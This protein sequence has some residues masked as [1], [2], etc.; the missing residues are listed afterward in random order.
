MPW[1]GTE[2]AMTALDGAGRPADRSLVAGGPTESVLHP[3]FSPAGVLW[4]VSD[5]SGWW[6]LYRMRDGAVEPLAPL[7]ADFGAAPWVFGLSTFGFVGDETVVCAFQRDGSWGLGLLQAGAPLEVIPSDLTEIA[8]VQGSPGRAVFAGGS[9]SSPMAI[10]ALEPTSRAVTILHRPSKA[11]MDEAL[12]SRPRPVRWPTGTATLAHGLH[13][14]PQN[15]D[16]SSPEGALPPLVVVSHGGPTA[17]AQTALSLSVQFWTSRGFAVLDVNYRGSTGYGR[18]YRQALEG[19][20]GIADVEDCVAGAR[21]LAALGL[22][23]ADRL[24]IRGS[25]AGGYTTL[26]ALA[27]HDTFRAGAS[28]YG[29]SD[30]ET[31]ATDTHKFESRYLDTLIGPYP[32][33]RDLYV[34]RSPLHHAERFS[35]PVIFFQGLED[36]VVPPEQAERMVEALRRKG[37]EAPYV[38]FP[39]EQHGFRRA[40]NITRALTEELAFYRRVLG[41][42]EAERSL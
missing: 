29:V 22:A 42:P 27:F 40:E 28:H 13:Y 41:L 31:L 14:P 11:A 30:L 33:R 26:A 9:P 19:Q 38:T 8:W 3:S 36:K 35:C 34:A 2:L 16:W 1:D 20:W 24:V 17:S 10:V 32:Q 15:P 39:D 21:H 6:N 4:F 23:D 5:R 18:A 25:S 12:V 7:A 37:L